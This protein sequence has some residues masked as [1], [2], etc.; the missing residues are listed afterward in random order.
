M[1][2]WL[3]ISIKPPVIVYS[4]DIMIYVTGFKCDI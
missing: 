1:I 4:V 2:E 3:T